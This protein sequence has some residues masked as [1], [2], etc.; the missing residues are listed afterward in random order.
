VLPKPVPRGTPSEHAFC[1]RRVK[2]ARPARIRRT[3]PPTFAD[4]DITTASATSSTWTKARSSASCAAIRSTFSSVGIITGRSTIV[5]MPVRVVHAA[6]SPPRVVW[7]SRMGERPAE[8]DGRQPAGSPARP[9]LRR[10]R[11]PVPTRRERLGRLR[12]AL[13]QGGRAR[14][15]AR[16]W[17]RCRQPCRRGRGQSR[18]H[19]RSRRTR[20][21]RRAPQPRHAG[22]RR[23]RGQI[24][25]RSSPLSRGVAQ[26]P[27]RPDLPPR[28]QA[29]CSPDHLHRSRLPP[30]TGSKPFAVSTDRWLLG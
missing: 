30:N 16:W 8:G 1:L 18:R 29:R 17:P 26:R 28:S 22:R 12:G 4:R 15:R 24:D 20:P 21:R 6:T 19:A 2:V 5:G 9:L 7:T 27:D 14:C 10:N 25:E 23:S 3:L 11:R 13:R